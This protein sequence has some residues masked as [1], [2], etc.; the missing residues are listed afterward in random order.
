M[1]TD[2]AE[3]ALKICASSPSADKGFLNL[4]FVGIGNNVK[5]ENRRIQFIFTSERITI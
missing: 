2:Y 1:N 4:E 3:K 5:Y